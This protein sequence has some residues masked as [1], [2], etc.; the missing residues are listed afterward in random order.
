LESPMQE[1]NAICAIDLA[2]RHSAALVYLGDGSWEWD[3]FSTRPS[4]KADQRAA[5]ESVYHG[6]ECAEELV[7]WLRD[8]VLARTD[9]A[10]VA[11]EIA[12]HAQS[13]GALIALALARG[14]FASISGALKRR[15]VAVE[16]VVQQ[17]SR[18]AV[19]AERPK[20]VRIPSSLKK[21]R[22]AI[23]KLL[24]KHPDQERAMRMQAIDK[25]I[26]D[27]KRQRADNRDAIK[28]AVERRILEHFPELRAVESS[29]GADLKEHVL[30]A[31][32][33]MVAASTRAAADAIADDRVARLRA[34]SVL[35]TV[36]AAS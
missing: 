7:D 3:V 15:G 5:F 19:L 14:A 32:S 13:S 9:L 2:L 26:R 22:D 34:A 28:A 21:E 12:T 1:R 18:A 33:V 10:L 36:G 35:A 31:A 25:V 23:A 20:A 17:H 4:R 11:V 8:F 24:K 16:L 27:A 30:D 6:Q 29:V